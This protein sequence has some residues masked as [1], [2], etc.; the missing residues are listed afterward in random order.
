M[1][2]RDD[3]WKL[4]AIVVAV[5]GAISSHALTLPPRLVPYAADIEFVCGIVAVVAAVLIK[6]NGG[7]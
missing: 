4:C 5:T 6:P 2:H 1:I 7:R 3:L